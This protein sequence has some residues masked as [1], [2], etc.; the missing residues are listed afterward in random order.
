[1]LK[2]I[3][4]QVLQ[5]TLVVDLSPKIQTAIT[6]ANELARKLKLPDPLILTFNLEELSPENLAVYGSKIYLG[7]VASGTAKVTL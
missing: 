4:I 5:K 3:L 6:K 2:P 1:M 7:V